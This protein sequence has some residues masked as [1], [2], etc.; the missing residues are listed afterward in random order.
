MDK[1]INKKENNE[2][3]SIIDA[4][5]KKKKKIINLIQMQADNEY[6]SNIPTANTTFQNKFLKP[7]AL[8]Y[9]EKI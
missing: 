4:E 1:I 6:N 9:E 5:D 7:Q 2:Y 8:Y 3:R